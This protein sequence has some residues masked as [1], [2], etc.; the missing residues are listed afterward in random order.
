MTRQQIVRRQIVIGVTVLLLALIALGIRSYLLSFAYQVPLGTLKEVAL[1]SRGPI[2]VWR[3]PAT[4]EQFRAALPGYRPGPGY[5]G[6]VHA[7]QSLSLVLKDDQGREVV[8]DLP[9]EEGPMVSIAPSPKYPRGNSWSMP[10]LLGLLGRLGME[11]LE[12]QGIDDPTARY[13]LQHWRDTFGK[14]KTSA[15]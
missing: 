4:L 15:V 5:K 11:A 7:H 1:I 12:A 3:D 6:Y 9:M 2:V 13:Y 14:G 10:E 8:L